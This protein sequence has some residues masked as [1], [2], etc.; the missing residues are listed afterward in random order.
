MQRDTRTQI[1]LNRKKQVCTSNV[2]YLQAVVNYTIIYLTDGRSVVVSKT[3]K[4]LEHR[5]MNDNNFFRTHKSFIVNLDFVT[6]FRINEEMTINVNEEHQVSLSRRRKD[7]F[8]RLA[9]QNHL[10]A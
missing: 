4:Q 2:L 1:P 10:A 3:L 5:L 9:R 7:D 8:L 6:G